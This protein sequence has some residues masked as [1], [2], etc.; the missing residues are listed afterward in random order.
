MGGPETHQTWTESQASPDE[1]P[2]ESS[3]DN[4]ESMTLSLSES[5][6]FFTYVL[7]YLSS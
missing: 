3:S 7:H 6:Y 1:M 5:S 2:Y 4:Y